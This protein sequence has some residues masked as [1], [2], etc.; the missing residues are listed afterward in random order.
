M[1]L[2][3]RVPHT[4]AMLARG[5]ELGRG[6]DEVLADG[7]P[8]PDVRLMNL[9]GH[10]HHQCRCLLAKDLNLLLCHAHGQLATL[11][12]G[13]NRHGSGVPVGLRLELPLHPLRV[14]LDGE[15]FLCLGELAHAVV[16]LRLHLLPLPAELIQLFPRLGPVP[17]DN[18]VGLLCGVDHAPRGLG[19]M[20]LDCLA[21]LRVLPGSGAFVVHLPGVLPLGARGRIFR[22]GDLTLCGRLNIFAFSLHFRG[23]SLQ[24]VQSRRAIVLK[25]LEHSLVPCA[26][27]GQPILRPRRDLVGLSPQFL[28]LPARSSDRAGERREMVLRAKRFKSVGPRRLRDG[29]D[30]PPDTSRSTHH[31]C[32]NGMGPLT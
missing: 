17:R 6:A 19:V 2:R 3:H 22:L 10:V 24:H 28:L 29:P 32:D 27:D 4:N 7:R 14:C 31:H 12:D 5:R 15:D 21:G 18:H 13:V 20:L 8:R 25:S 23:G 1:F 11:A 16:H 30:G 26:S 9:H